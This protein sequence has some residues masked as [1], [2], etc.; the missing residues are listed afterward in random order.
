[1]ALPTGCLPAFEEKK[2]TQQPLRRYDV[3]TDNTEWGRTLTSVLQLEEKIENFRNSFRETQISV[4]QVR[5]LF[6][7]HHSPF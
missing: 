6:S 3:N 1:M 2:R 7:V 5:S 4:A